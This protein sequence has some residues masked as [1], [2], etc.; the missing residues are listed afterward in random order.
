MVRH[1]SRAISLAKALNVEPAAVVRAPVSLA[2]T[3]PVRGSV[4]RA[5][6]GEIALEFDD[7]VRLTAL[8]LT[9]WTDARVEFGFSIVLKPA[10][11][12][13][14]ALPT[15]TDGVYRVAWRART[16][17][18]FRLEGAFGFTVSAPAA[19]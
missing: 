9:D 12:H 15:L 14:Y 18:G 5:V 6:P 7:D 2:A 1:V 13:R 17:D 10:S 16:P 11:A 8:V 4:C 3:W 19:P